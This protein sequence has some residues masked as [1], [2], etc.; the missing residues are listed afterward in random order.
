VDPDFRNGPH[1]RLAPASDERPVVFMQ[2]SIWRYIIMRRLFFGL[3]AALLLFP[4]TM[5]SALAAQDATPASPLADLGLPT[6]DIT[7]SAAGY[8]GIPDTLEA[9]RYL[10]T[11]SAA[12]D[13]AD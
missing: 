12:D 10:V 2:E 5:L 7:V 6:L 3:V 4:A 1:R 11:V 13:T 9:G 8:E